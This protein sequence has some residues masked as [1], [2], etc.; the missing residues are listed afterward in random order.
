[1]A[2]VN[3]SREALTSVRMSLN[4]FKTEIS[5]VPFSMVRSA[6]MLQSEC[7]GALWKVDSQISQLKQQVFSKDAQLRQ[8]QDDLANARERLEDTERAKENIER[9][10]AGIERERESCERELSHLRAQLSSCD[11]NGRNQCQQAVHGAE[12]RLSELN[13]H[14]C[15]AAAD[16]QVQ[17][18]MMCRL[19]CEIERIITAI[20]DTESELRSLKEELSKK[21]MKRDRMDRAFN[22]LMSE[23]S[24]FR[25][26]V[27][28]FTECAL[29]QTQQDITSVEQ[30]IQYIDD[31]LATNL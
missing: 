16:L 8:L 15:E 12:N 6:N 26:S 7:Q 9:T 20:K 24:V 1:M 2:R 14:E 11:E 29:T 3:V 22:N 18:N 10:L 21:E 25:N 23:L 17:E 31:Y 19:N 4:Q 28:R 30:C 5:D 27:R 13:G